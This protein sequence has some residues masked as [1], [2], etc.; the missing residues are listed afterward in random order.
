MWEAEVEG[1]RLNFHLAGINNQNFIMSDDETG[2]W[3]QQVSGEAIQGPLKGKKLI[4][5]YHD[6]ITFG[7]WKRENPRGRVLK[8]DERVKQHY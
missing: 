4:Q 7:L 8:P 5:V 1:K 2:S 3:W 6:E